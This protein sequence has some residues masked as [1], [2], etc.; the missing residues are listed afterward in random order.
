MSERRAKSRDGDGHAAGALAVR[1]AGL[2][3]GGGGLLEVGDGFNRDGRGGDDGEQTRQ[4]GAHLGDVVRE[5]IH[6]GLLGGG[7]VLGVGFDG[8]AEGGQIGEPVGP[9]ERGHLGGDAVVL[10][11]A[12]GVDLRRGKA[13]GGV[14]ADGG[15]VAALA[16]GQGFNGERG[17]AGG[18]VVG[19]DEGGELLIGGQHLGVDGGG[20]AVGQAGFIGRG[21]ACGKLLERESGRGRRR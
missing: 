11:Q 1:R 7:D 6:D 3:V 9:G 19:G 8:G 21:E 12:D 13:G 4:H 16:A 17:A 14:A 15:L 10:G 5:V 18:H 2:I 20:D